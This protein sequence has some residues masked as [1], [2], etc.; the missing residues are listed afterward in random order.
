MKSFEQVY[1]SKSDHLTLGTDQ[2]DLEATLAFARAHDL[3]FVIETK[4]ADALRQSC[5]FELFSKNQ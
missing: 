3:S 2:D 5:R 1:A 4:T